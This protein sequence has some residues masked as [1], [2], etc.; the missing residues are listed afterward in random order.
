MSLD[1]AELNSLPDLR[2]IPSSLGLKLQ[3]PVYVNPQIHDHS[4]NKHMGNMEESAHERKHFSWL[5]QQF[6]N[7]FGLPTDSYKRRGV[8]SF[9]GVQLAEG[10]NKVVATWQGLFY[11]L[12]GED[13]IFENL[14]RSF[15]TARGT[16]IWSTKG[17]QITKLYREDMR[18]TPRPHRFA[19]MPNRN[20]SRP[21]NP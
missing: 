8:Y 13:I 12:K 9:D 6:E 16:T 15:N 18:T 10:F 21:C 17:V 7:C 19:V 1:K 20:S 4:N 5:K 11:E 2:S 14:D 3:N